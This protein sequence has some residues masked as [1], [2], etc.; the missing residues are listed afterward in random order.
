MLST[1]RS[2]LELPRH[3]ELEGQRI[4]LLV[5]DDLKEKPAGIVCGYTK[6]VKDEM[7]KVLQAQGPCFVIV[8]HKPVWD[9]F[10]EDQRFALLDH[11]ATHCGTYEDKNGETKL[12]IR[13]HDLQ[14][15]HCIVG[16]YGAR[17]AENR[18]QLSL[19]LAE[20]ATDQDDQ[21]DGEHAARMTAQGKPRP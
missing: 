10:N 18:P 17:W 3:E 8:I 5:R 7:V 12:F 14:E 21:D 16:A 6:L 11:E 15:F 19:D 4:D 13:P 2:V 9:A 1:L 20:P